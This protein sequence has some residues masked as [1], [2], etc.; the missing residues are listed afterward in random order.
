V[1]AAA[2]L[3]TPRPVSQELILTEGRG[4]TTL[5]KRFKR[6]MST[7]NRLADAAT[8]HALGT[9]RRILTLATRRADSQKGMDS[10]DES[11]VRR[12]RGRTLRL[13][14]RNPPTWADTTTRHLHP[15]DR[16]LHIKQ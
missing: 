4:Y 15:T 2:R 3:K 1:R 13:T 12:M 9:R 16:H 7:H 8:Q 10:E 5:D 11:G 6:L 14:K